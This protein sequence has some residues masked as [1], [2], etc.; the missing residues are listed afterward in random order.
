MRT[1]AHQNKKYSINRYISARICSLS[2]EKIGASKISLAPLF[3]LQFLPFRA[4][5][6]RD[7]DASGVLRVLRRAEIT[8]SPSTSHL[9]GETDRCLKRARAAGWASNRAR[10]NICSLLLTLN[11]PPLYCICLQTLWLYRCLIR[12][13]VNALAMIFRPRSDSAVQVEHGSLI[14]RSR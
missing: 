14:G 1:E 9:H 6:R 3:H 2:S 8:S 5:N 13:D 7:G 11:K 4:G 12:S 10:K